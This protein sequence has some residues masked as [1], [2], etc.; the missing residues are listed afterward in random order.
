M[1]TARPFGHLPLGKAPLEPQSWAG[2]AGLKY[3][4]SSEGLR[5]RHPGSPGRRSFLCDLCWTCCPLLSVWAVGAHGKDSV[6]DVRVAGISAL[7][8]S[9]RAGKLSLHGFGF[10]KPHVSTEVLTTQPHTPVSKCLASCTVLL[11]QTLFWG[12]KETPR[13]CVGAPG[14]S[15]IVLAGQV[16]VSQ[17]PDSA[18]TLQ[19]HH[20]GPT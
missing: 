16:R 20:P 12:A 9:N 6:R 13:W 15:Q 7:R 18:Q 2:G 4:V 3:Q 1:V 11:A 5:E 14:H 10:W 8:E 19:G 17:G